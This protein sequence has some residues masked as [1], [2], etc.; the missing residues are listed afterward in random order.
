MKLVNYRLELMG[1]IERKSLGWAFRAKD[2]K[3]FY[4]AKL[5]ISRP[6]PLPMVDLVHYPVTNGKE[7]AKIRVALPFAVLRS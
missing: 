5:T 2:E 3:N 6:G 7:G 1:Q 4:V